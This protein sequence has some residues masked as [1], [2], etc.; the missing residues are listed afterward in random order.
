[1]KTEPTTNSDTASVWVLLEGFVEQYRTHDEQQV[2][3]DADGRV[4]VLL[5]LDEGA[6]HDE[7]PP[8][9]GQRW[10]TQHLAVGRRQENERTFPA[11]TGRPS[12]WATVRPGPS[13]GRRPHTSDLLGMGAYG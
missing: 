6:D 2:P 1:M 7:I 10:C 4:D 8:S 9:S 13:A 12:W 11:V 5:V 3:A